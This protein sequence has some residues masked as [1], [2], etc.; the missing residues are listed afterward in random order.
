MMTIR[1]LTLGLLLVAAKNTAAQNFGLEL[2]RAEAHAQQIVLTAKSSGLRAVGEEKRT[3]SGDVELFVRLTQ[4]QVTRLREIAATARPQRKPI[5]RMG[6]GSAWRR[7]WARYDTHDEASDIDMI[8][9]SVRKS[10]LFGLN[11]QRID[12]RISPRTGT[13]TASAHDYSTTC[14]IPMLLLCEEKSHAIKNMDMREPEI[15]EWFR[16]ELDY[17]VHNHERSSN[18]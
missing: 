17:W 3:S 5:L 14:I 2:E 11:D 16:E 7:L 1:T 18:K 4:A 6:K 9:L 12:F 13:A 8:E 10:S 15:R